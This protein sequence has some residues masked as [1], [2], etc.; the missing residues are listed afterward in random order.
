MIRD[1]LG[2]LVKK[3]LGNHIWNKLDPPNYKFSSTSFHATWAVY[4][5]AVDFDIILIR[6]K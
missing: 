3:L 6:F 4:M 5:Y 2:P 1:Q